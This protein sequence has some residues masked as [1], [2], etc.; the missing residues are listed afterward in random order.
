MLSSY[1][2]SIFYKCFVHCPKSGSE[3]LKCFFVC[4]RIQAHK[5]K[6]TVS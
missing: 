6:R 3:N 1:G 2:G 5:T 4:D